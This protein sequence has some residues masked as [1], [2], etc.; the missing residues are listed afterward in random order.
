VRA[1][2]LAGERFSRGLTRVVSRT[3]QDERG[4]LGHGTFGD[5]FL[6]RRLVGTPGADDAL[7]AVKV[8]R[9][10]RGAAPDG[11]A[12]QQFAREA[13]LMRVA[14]SSAF[15]VQ[16]HD[17][18]ALRES[19]VLREYLVMELMEGRD[20]M[21]CIMA[22]ELAGQPLSEAE[23][24]GATWR[25]LRGLADMHRRGMPHRDVKPDN[26][27]LK[28]R[29]ADGLGDPLSAKLG[30]LGHAREVALPGAASGAGAAASLRTY[31]L[32]G[33]PAYNAPERVRDDVWA[34]GFTEKAD[35]WAVGVTLFCMLL[36]TFPFGTAAGEKAPLSEQLAK[37]EALAS[38]IRFED[39]APRAGT[40]GAVRL[41]RYS[42]EARDLLGRMLQKSEVARA[43]VDEALRHAWFHGISDEGT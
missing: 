30:D 21:R 16:F 39:W 29:G 32:L 3:A 15:V 1:C 20:L 12:C 6:A 19:G 34:S 35:V 8:P 42:P 7:V 2:L 25:V 36:A 18:F 38:N 10:E 33:T 5:C 26:V 31:S 17:Y 40:A 11:G 37:L 13:A 9:R 43:S 14:A 41:A 4:M 27:M 22:R 28:R 23:A 24:R